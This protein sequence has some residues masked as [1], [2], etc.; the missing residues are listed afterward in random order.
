MTD[1]FQLTTRPDAKLFYRKN[2]K[3]DPR[4]GEVVLCEPS[5]YASAHVVILGC[6]QDE[7]VRR[8]NGRPGAANAPAAIREQFYKLTPFNINKRVFD[9][10]NVAMA[11]SLE[12]THDVL[13]SVVVQV[14]RDGKR[15]IILGG[16]N[17]ISYADG[18]A[19]AE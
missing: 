16:G 18:R 10:G 11:G 13:T 6:A 8:N 15:L 19:M 1:I 9:L 17:D 14:L 7:G 4:L 5:S 3:F 2:D 12:E